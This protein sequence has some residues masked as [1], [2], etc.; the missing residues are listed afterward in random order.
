MTPHRLIRLLAC[1]ALIP[2]LVACG[3]KDGGEGSQSSA[4]QCSITLSQLDQ[5]ELGMDLPA[6][7]AILGE[8]KK[9]SEYTTGEETNVGYTW[10]GDV[11]RNYLD[12]P[13]IEIT[14]VNG[15]VDIV[16]PYNIP[17]N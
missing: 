5:I 7:E 16:Q 3:S 12:G 2:A 13:V 11:E 17:A 1:S 15:K 9:D 8:G 4:N 6:V 10:C 14:F